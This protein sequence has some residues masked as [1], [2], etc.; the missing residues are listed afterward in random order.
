MQTRSKLSVVFFVYSEHLVI[1]YFRP[2]IIL[3][4]FLFFY[5]VT[6]DFMFIMQIKL[7]NQMKSNLRI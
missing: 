1:E 4:A 6:I 5:I 3:F 2:R 7:S